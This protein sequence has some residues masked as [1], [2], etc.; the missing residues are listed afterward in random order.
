MGRRQLCSSGGGHSSAQARRVGPRPSRPVPSCT[1]AAGSRC[2]PRAEGGGGEAHAASLTPRAAAAAAEE[3]QDA[4]DL[5]EG[6]GVA[7]DAQKR[8]YYW[9]KKTKKTLWEKPTAETPIN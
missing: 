2:L 4:V 9:H 1:A 8:P 3:K 7:Y 5:P 6:W